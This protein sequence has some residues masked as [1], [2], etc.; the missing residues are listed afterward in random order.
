MAVACTR[1]G[2]CQCAPASTL[3][4]RS[5]SN[6]DGYI[7]ARTS[8]SPTTAELWKPEGNIRKR[9]V[10]EWDRGNNKEWKW[11]EGGGGVTVENI[12]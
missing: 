8:D 11:E 7:I 4:Q 2:G 3:N 9:G 6:Q 12:T 5:R 10:A 1:T